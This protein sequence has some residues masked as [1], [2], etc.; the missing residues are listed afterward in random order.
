M[1]KVIAF[2]KEELEKY[3]KTLSVKAEIELHLF[4]EV[5]IKAEVK[6]PYLDDALKIKVTN[7]K[8]YIAGINPRSILFGVYRLLEEWG[9]VWVRPGK[10]GTYIPPVASVKDVD[11]FEIA[12]K[13]H[14]TMCIEGAVSL[15]NVL[16]MVDW[17]PK[18]GYNGYYIQ[19]ENSCT[20]FEKWYSHKGSPVKE[21]EYFD[22]AMAD[23]FV[24]IIEKAVK[25]RGLLLMRMGHGWTCNPFG[26]VANGWD[27]IKPEDIPQEYKDICALVD[28]R[29]EVWAGSPLM[30]ELCYSNPKV[31]ETMTEAVVDY[32]K[33]HPQTDVIHFWLGD[34]FNNNCE[35]PECTKYRLSD[36]QTMMVNQITTRFKEENIKAQVVFS[37]GGNKV[38]PPIHEQVSHPEHTILMFAPASRT[39]ARSFPDGYKVKDIPEYKVNGYVRPHTVED[40]L[41]YLYNWKKQYTGDTIAFEYH[42][43]WDHLIEASGEGTAKILYEDV[44]S[45]KN[46]GINS[47]I[48]C[49]LQRNSFPTALGMTVLGKTL[50]NDEV[51]Y[52]EIK[53]QL[54]VASFGEDKYNEMCDYF[55]AIREAFYLGNIRSQYPT[56]REEFAQKLKKAIEKMEAMIS[57]AKTNSETERD[58]CRSKSWLMVHYHARIYVLLAKSVLEHINGNLKASKALRQSSFNTAWECEDHIQDAFDCHFYELVARARINLDGILNVVETRNPFEE[59]N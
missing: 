30:T 2:A 58:A 1:D 43:M 19:F 22:N 33:K 5:N 8:G 9:I 51:D 20:F 16:D 32:M 23:K 59:N 25:D 34:Y 21:P 6:D 37:M 17:M 13:R 31:R 10:D 11:I 29:R 48:S 52:D 44:R 47:F 39:Y 41:A 56:S 12:Q 55:G 40:L 36:Y 24:E 15:E 26:V 27:Q 57:T 38:H 53:K 54:Y 28:G 42:L 46:L 4:D 35:C 45:Y 49:Q 3:L 14:R 7:K 18:A 50:W